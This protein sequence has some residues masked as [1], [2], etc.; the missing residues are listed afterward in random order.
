MR[1]LYPL[2]ATLPDNLFPLSVTIQ[3]QSN[4]KDAAG[5]RIE[6]YS[7]LFTEKCLFTTGVRGAVRDQG[8]RKDDREHVRVRGNILVN[9][10]ADIP[11]GSRAVIVFP[12]GHGDKTEYW[13]VI[14]SEHRPMSDLTRCSIELF[15]GLI[16]G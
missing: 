10:M 8:L 6:E 2:K 5:Q 7:D 13:R 15:D 16:R 14:G 12:E 3:T 9:R 11:Y 4:D 1:S